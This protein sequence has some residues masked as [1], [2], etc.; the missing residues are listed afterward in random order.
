MQA[1][2]EVL[3]DPESLPVGNLF[4]THN[5]ALMGLTLAVVLLVINQLF[6]LC[7]SGIVLMDGRYLNIL[8]TIF[9]AATFL[10]FNLRCERFEEVGL[11][12][13]ALA[14]LALASGG[15][16]TIN[17]MENVN[18]G[19]EFAAP[20]TALRPRSRVG[21]DAAVVGYTRTYTRAP[22]HRGDRVQ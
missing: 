13:W 17:A 6:N 22:S 2:L 20:P 10:I 9:L 8:V 3:K 11:L 21:L 4:N 1:N 16:L 7:T 14:T 12:V 5:I 18:Q 19:G 15:S